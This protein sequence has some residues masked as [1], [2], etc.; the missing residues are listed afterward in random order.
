MKKQFMTDFSPETL[1]FSTSGK[2]TRGLRM[3]ALAQS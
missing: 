1:S 2:L 3:H